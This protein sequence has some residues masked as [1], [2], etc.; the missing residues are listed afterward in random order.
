[1][2]ERLQVM[3]ALQHRNRAVNLAIPIPLLFAAALVLFGLLA[4]TG[5][6]GQM[7]VNRH[8]DP[9]RLSRL[10]AENY[11]LKE[12]LTHYA[13]AVDTFRMFMDQTEEM[14]N[15]L[16]SATDL[17]LIPADVRAM[18]IGGSLPDARDELLG[19]LLNRVHFAER[20]L[21][22]V[23]TA[24]SAQAGRLQHMPSIWP[25]QGWVTSGFG[26]RR[27]PFTGQQRLHEGIDI[28]APYGSGM[29]APAAGRVVS[30]GW[31]SSWGR[32]LEIDH[33]NG[34]R[35]FF[36]HCR[37]ISVGEGD[38]VRRGQ[39]VATVG[40]SGRST[41]THLHYGVKRNGNWVNPRDY[42]ISPL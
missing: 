18:G 31:Q 10:V 33:G 9:G 29:V 15:R 14:D 39:R 7:L 40:S 20:S 42:I 26:Y 28:V 35:T 30:A 2:V 32:T 24:L 38:A 36:A 27:D 6:V 16:R 5:F 17:C 3:V 37:T 13:A 25:V 12:K 19:N 41:G 23:D 4:L 11:T 8:T 1:M 21:A 22:E 34:I